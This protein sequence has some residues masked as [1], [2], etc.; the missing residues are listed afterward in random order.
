LDPTGR[1][2]AGATV[3]AI[4]VSGGSADGVNRVLQTGDRRSAPLATLRGPL[5]EQRP[6][7][8]DAD[9]RFRLTGLGRDRL[10]VLGLEG[11]VIPYTGLVVATRPAAAIP[12]TSAIRGASFEHV[13]PAPQVIRGV[14]RDQA[15]GQPVAGVRATVRSTRST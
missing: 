6:Q 3:R 11:P 10:A 4:D 14:V 8:T 9:G 12:P 7:V 13:A 15:T 2:V 5:P 1:P